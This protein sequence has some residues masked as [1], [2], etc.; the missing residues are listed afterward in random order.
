M[1]HHSTRPGPDPSEL[2]V[3][4]FVNMQISRRVRSPNSNDSMSD[5][6][7]IATLNMVH[8]IKSKRMAP[9]IVRCLR[10]THKNRVDFARATRELAS[11][12]DQQP[13]VL[14][15]STPEDFV[16]W[17]SRMWSFGSESSEQEEE[18]IR[19]M[20][21]EPENVDLDKVN[22]HIWCPRCK[23][24]KVKYFQLQ[25]RSIDEPMTIFARCL[26]PT[27]RKRFKI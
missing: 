3:P 13:D 11:H 1:Y 10:A 20:L 18:W 7:A 25:T 14:D 6:K 26:I 22:S 19:E 12:L 27:C 15:T 8:A 5:A 9:N 16:L 17:D 23:Q 2:P 24:N 21:P 4:P